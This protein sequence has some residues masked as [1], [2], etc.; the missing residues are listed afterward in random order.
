MKKELFVLAILVLLNITTKAQRLSEYKAVNGIT[1]KENDTVRLGKGSGVNAS[2]VFLKIGSLYDSNI[3]KNY[4][5]YENTFAVIKKIKFKGAT[6][7]KK[8][9][10]IVDVGYSANYTLVID[11]AIQA[12]EVIPCKKSSIEKIDVAD[13]IMKL[14]KLLDSGAI[15]QAEYD[16]QKKKLLQEN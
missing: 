12:C 15:T 3:D 7:R 8:V 9:T 13:E 11:E 1:Y 4:Y 5:K 6:D 2:F 16:N 10:F 14:K